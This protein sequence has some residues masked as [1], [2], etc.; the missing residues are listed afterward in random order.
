MIML[1][2]SL[3][4]ASLYLMRLTTFSFYFLSPSNWLI[5]R[6][7]L[8]AELPYFFALGPCLLILYIKI[9]YSFSLSEEILAFAD[10]IGPVIVF[11]FMTLYAHYYDSRRRSLVLLVAQFLL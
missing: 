3:D 8:I 7:D 11:V 4:I 2:V 9:V 1:V 6:A 5:L 10:L